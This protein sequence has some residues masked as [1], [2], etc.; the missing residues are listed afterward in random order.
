[1]FRGKAVA[2]IRQS[3]GNVSSRIKVSA[4]KFGCNKSFSFAKKLVTPK[5]IA[6]FTTTSGLVLGA[7]FYIKHSIERGE[8]PVG[9][10][11][12]VIGA[13]IVNKNGKA[14]EQ[15]YKEKL[16][17]ALSDKILYLNIKDIDSKL[18]LYIFCNGDKELGF[19]C[20]KLLGK[21]VSLNSKK[22]LN[23]IRD[24]IHALPG[25]H[26]SYSTFEQVW[27]V[28]ECILEFEAGIIDRYTNEFKD[29]DLP[30]VTHLRHNIGSKEVN[31]LYK[32]LPILEQALE[33]E[34]KEKKLGRVT[35]YHGDNCRQ[36]LARDFFKE[37]YQKVNEVDLPNDYMFL[38]FG[39]VKEKQKALNLDLES[40]YTH[41]Y[42]SQQVDSSKI[43]KFFWATLSLF[44]AGTGA[45]PV[46]YFSGNYDQLSL[47]GSVPAIEGICQDN[48]ISSEQFREEI[49]K[50][51]KLFDKCHKSGVLV[52]YSVKQDYLDKVFYPS[53]PGMPLL[54]FSKASSVLNDMLS[55]QKIS[56]EEHCGII[57]ALER[58]D[59]ARCYVLADR[60]EE[61]Y[62]AY[63]KA[64]KELV[65][66]L[67]YSR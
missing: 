1:M 44:A 24:I 41:L 47:H 2:F 64:L 35:L 20:A 53:S 12:S 16:A 21:K 30:S 43:N 14:I 33:I 57:N 15:K 8:L 23:S 50:V 13:Y 36:Q 37:L 55:G 25:C 45:S 61:A 66:K 29:Y 31:A 49:L 62:V 28:D 3:V 18:V 10:P 7:H 58:S 67:T 22:D 52:V 11:F 60:D 27:K 54:K 38:R 26:Y 51:G 34:L 5:R 65:I 39:N 19:K 63:Q 40:T 46:S 59:I 6:S 4:F 17:N 42:Q 48:G 32:S 9:V 56:H